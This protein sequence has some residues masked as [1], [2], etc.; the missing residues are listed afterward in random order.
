MKL[1]MSPGGNTSVS[2]GGKAFMLLAVVGLGA[3]AALNVR[4]IQR[5]LNIR[6][7]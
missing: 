1:T 6:R 2:V 3:L 5:Y 4:D 7:M